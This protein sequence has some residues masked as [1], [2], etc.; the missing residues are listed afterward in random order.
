MKRNINYLTI[1]KKAQKY[2]TKYIKKYTNF[3]TTTQETYKFSNKQYS[4]I[5]EKVYE[6]PYNSQ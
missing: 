3:N 2:L 1:T 6:F 5:P 4:K